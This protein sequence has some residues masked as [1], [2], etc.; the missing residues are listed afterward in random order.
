M[1]IGV[2][3]GSGQIGRA[4]IAELAS[5]GHEHRVIDI[6]R[7]HGYGGDYRRADL[8][9]LWQTMDALEGTDAVIHLAGVGA[10]G[11][12]TRYP[13]LADQ[14]TFAANTTATFNVFSA[15]AALGIPRVVWASSETVMGCPFATHPPEFLPLT[16]EHPV[17]PEYSYALSKALGEEAAAYA[18]RTSGIAVTTLRF[19]VVLDQAAYQDLPRQWGAPRLGRWNLWSY[20]DIQDAAASCRIAVEAR[21]AGVETFIIAAPDTTMDQPT[22]ELLEMFAPAP[23][24]GPLRRFQSLQSTDKAAS[25]LGFRPSRT[26][27]EHLPA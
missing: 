21:R 6:G 1:L 22:G 24:R 5:H 10:P 23:M 20:V 8:R 19:S 11:E 9:E 26:W 17:R 2:T 7:G 15:A 16:E 25:V 3:G 13:L 14:A 4:V 18:N 12:S 27:R